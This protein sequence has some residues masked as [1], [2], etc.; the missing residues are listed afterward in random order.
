[1]DFLELAKTRF[2]VRKFKNQPVEEEKLKLIL[3]AGHVAPTAANKQ[4]Q[5][6]LIIQSGEAL[7]KL[8]QC[9]GSHFNAPLALLVCYDKDTTWVRVRF[10]QK[11]SGDVDASI[12]TTH[13]MLEAANIGIG[14]TWVMHFDPEKIR[15]SFHIPQNIEPVALLVM[16]Y[17]AEDAVPSERHFQKVE[18]GAVLIYN[19]FA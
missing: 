16:G 6:I 8:K 9:T 3:Q 18:Q 2:S 19:D 4:P 11:N 5:R 7:E 10:D 1:M 13:M 14:S 12:V 15:E 17:A